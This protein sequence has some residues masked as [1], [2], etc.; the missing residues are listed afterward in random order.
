MKKIKFSVLIL[1][2]NFGLLITSTNKS[3]AKNRSFYFAIFKKA[4]E[5]AING[6]YLEALELYA[7]IIKQSPYD[8]TANYG[9]GRVLLLIPRDTKTKTGYQTKKKEVTRA[10]RHLRLSV[11]QDPSSAKNH[12]Y[13]GFAYYFANYKD[14]AVYEFKKAVALDPSFHE[15]YFNIAMILEQRKEMVSAKKFFDL[16]LQREKAKNSIDSFDEF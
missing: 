16:Y 8:S 6:K 11:K 2:I 3:P 9:I 14:L 5:A 7:K 10:L 15:S 12:F 1:I 13:L 4:R